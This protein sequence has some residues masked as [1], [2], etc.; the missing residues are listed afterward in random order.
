GASTYLHLGELLLARHDTRG[1][2]ILTKNAMDSWTDLDKF[3]GYPSDLSY[4]ARLRQ[5]LESATG[6]DL[7]V[8]KTLVKDNA[9]ELKSAW[10]TWLYRNKGK[11][12]WD[13]EKKLF[14]VKK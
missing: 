12:E 3:F 4:K 7:G 13:K 1:F 14:L 2:E 8:P 11:I 5:V 10:Q 9:W 6:T